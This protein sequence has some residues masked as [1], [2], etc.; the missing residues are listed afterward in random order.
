MKYCKKNFKPLN[1]FLEI[2]FFHLIVVYIF[3]T[4]IKN[5]TNFRERLLCSKPLPKDLTLTLENKM[6]AE[7]K[8]KLEFISFVKVTV[9][10]GINFFQ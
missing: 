7:N 6:I 5:N 10:K 8:M 1:Y 3:F 4:C 9:N 2:K